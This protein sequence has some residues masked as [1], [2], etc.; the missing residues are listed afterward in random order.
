MTLEA[1]QGRLERHFE[2]L[3]SERRENRWPVFALEHGLNSEERGN[4]EEE[5]RQAAQRAAPMGRFWLP[6][7][8]YAAEIG[9]RYLGDEYWQTFEQETPGWLEYGDRDFIKRSFFHFHRHFG[10]AKPTGRWA[11]RFTIICWPITHAILPRD[12]QR[13][14]ARVLHE[15]RFDFSSEVFAAPGALGA[16]VAARSAGTKP[17]FQQFVQETELVDQIASALL[18]HGRSQAEPL[19]LP[20]TLER[21]VADLDGERGAGTWLR[22]AQRVAHQVTVRGLGHHGGHSGATAQPPCVERP[23]DVEP[24]FVLRPATSGGWDVLLELPDLSPLLLW[25]AYRETLTSARC[26]VEG[27]A[28]PL[29]RGRVLSGADLVRLEHWPAPG[30]P[31][32]QFEDA[33]DSLAALLVRECVLPPGPPWLFRIRSDGLAY[34][35]RGRLARAGRSYL[36]AWPSG[37]AA[38]GTLLQSE[39][40]TCAGLDLARLDLPELLTPEYELELRHLGLGTGSTLHFWPVGLPPRSW[41]GEGH[42]VWLSTDAPLLAVEADH[43]LRSLTLHVPGTGDPPLRLTNVGTGVPAFVELPHLAVGHHRLDVVA[44]EDGGE[45]VRAQLEIVVRVPE[46]WVPERP[47]RRLLLL[48]VTPAEPTLEELLQGRVAVELHGPVGRKVTPR[49]ILRDLSL[50]GSVPVEKRLPPLALP[51]TEASWRDAFDRAVLQDEKTLDVADGAAMAQIDFDAEDL[52]VLTVRC[53]RALTPVR[54]VV[55]RA[56]QRYRLRLVDDSSEVA[57]VTRHDLS[58]PERAVEVPLAAALRGVDAPE[59]GALY[60]A[61]ARDQPCAI[62]LPR[63]RLKGFAGLRVSCTFESQPRRA[64]SIETLLVLLE[65]FAA[66][67]VVGGLLT[68]GFQRQVLEALHERIL[69]VICGDDWMRLERSF[70]EK[71][72]SAAS[73]YQLQ[74]A[75]PAN[76]RQRRVV[77]KLVAE[78]LSKPLQ[79][80]ELVKAFEAAAQ[81]VIGGGTQQGWIGEFELRLA[82]APESLRAWAGKR[83]REGLETSLAVS[84]VTRFGRYVGLARSAQAGPTRLALPL[85]PDW[86]WSSP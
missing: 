86:T 24:R 8:V 52:G 67:R 23:P 72:P 81:D 71:A 84:S 25:E 15:A 29:A 54:W 4:L 59:G 74:E 19:L 31:L 3:S 20:S 85:V 57:R 73:L 39:W 58:A 10:G 27:A 2:G 80:A 48:E 56:G 78:R 26:I 42:A 65:R 40:T 1:W 50:G 62:L 33:P 7:A 5:I 61:S 18:F 11:E 43:A 70:R 21:I 45:T 68:I 16:R 30:R 53:P 55:R 44:E 49:L 51:V 75:V 60:V 69:N 66:A 35:I 32:L 37:A 46:P 17:R 64:E 14:L 76:P 79:Q 82:T 38:H 36:L 47:S 22:E 77:V 63:P 34:E 41:D 28:R 83:L 12:L 13:E 9:Y 6:W